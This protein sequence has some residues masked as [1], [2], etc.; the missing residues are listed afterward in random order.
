VKPRKYFILTYPPLHSMF[1]NVVSVSNR[2]DAL[3]Y[4]SY[5][6]GEI[7]S[8]KCAFPT[9]WYQSCILVTRNVINTQ[10]FQILRINQVFPLMYMKS[11]TWV[12]TLRSEKEEWNFCF[13]AST[14]ES[15]ILLILF[16]MWLIYFIVSDNIV[17]IFSN[18][19]ENS[20]FINVCQLNI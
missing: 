16:W 19:A 18:L 3:N 4:T 11:C 20:V 17:L 1:A 12:L 2:S 9:K 15:L 5:H 14:S 8:E 7:C 13:I 10:L 6:G